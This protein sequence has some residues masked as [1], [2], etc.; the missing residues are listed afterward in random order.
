MSCSRVSYSTSQTIPG[1]TVR[2]LHPWLTRFTFLWLLVGLFAATTQPV[3]ACTP[4]PPDPWLR[5]EYTVDDSS[6]PYDTTMS[7]VNGLWDA[8]LHVS[9]D[10]PKTFYILAPEGKRLAIVTRRE[11]LQPI[12]NIDVVREALPSLWV[13]ALPS[14]SVS[15]R[16]YEEV[17]PVDYVPPAP[18]HAELHLLYDNERITL[19]VTATY[20]LNPDYD[21]NSYDNYKDS[22]FGCKYARAKPFLCMS[23]AGIIMIS[24][25]FATVIKLFSALQG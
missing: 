19:P 13:E 4:S 17:R 2:A 18:H 14:L 6:L 1:I 3:G 7:F 25:G 8:E 5:E 24:V 16:R 9:T 10:A 11:G 12:G 23:V 15:D 20:K 21:P 22:L